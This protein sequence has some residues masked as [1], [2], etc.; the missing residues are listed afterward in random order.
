MCVDHVFII[1][2]PA[3]GHTG[4]FYFLAVMN[5]TAM[6]MDGHIRVSVAGHEVLWLYT[7]R[8]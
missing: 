7:Q 5:R 2:S 4:W 8:V 1:H 6:N 3:D